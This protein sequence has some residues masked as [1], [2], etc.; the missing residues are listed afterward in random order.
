MFGFFWFC[1]AVLTFLVI[2]I[3]GLF[4]DQPVAQRDES[5]IRNQNNQRVEH[6]FTPSRNFRTYFLKIGNKNKEVI[7]LAD[8]QSL[9]SVRAILDS[10]NTSFICSFV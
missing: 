5:K 6:K 9:P 2:L 7:L 1:Y 3:S 4:K 8:I 10:E